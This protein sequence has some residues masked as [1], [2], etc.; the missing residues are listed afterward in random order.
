[1]K[2]LN[3]K[4][5]LAFIVL[6]GFAFASLSVT[7]YSVSASSFKPGSRGIVTVVISNPSTSNALVNTINVNP[8]APPQIVIG[9]SQFVGDLEIGG[10]TTVSVPFS[11]LPNA[12]SGIYNVVLDVTGVADHSSGEGFNAFSRKVTIPV[13]VV[14]SPILSFSSDKLTISDIDSINLSITNNGGPA[15]NVRIST[16]FSQS[17]ILSGTDQLFIP[18]VSSSASTIMSLDSRDLSDGPSSIKL[19]VEY[20]DELGISHSDNYT[21]RLAVKKQKLDVV[22]SQSSPV[23]TRKEGSFSLS[24][25]NTGSVDLKDVRLVFLN[26]SIKVKDS[27]EL[28]FGDLAPLSSSS[29]NSVAMIDLPPGLNHVMATLSWVEKDVQKE[30]QIS[31]PLTVTSDAD[32]GVYLEA[33]PSPLVAGADHTVSVLVSN[34]GSYSIGILRRSL[35]SLTLPV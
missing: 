28:K 26:D 14:N 10:S 30:E 15:S 11:V 25:R 20:N 18:S 17:P 8:T 35:R 32:V 12:Q 5:M 19:L 16:P 24:I 27:A 33:K 23:L 21:L 31:V 34:I 3:L 29:V 9:N 7:S 1:M 6:M 2:N 13:T 22:F 4:I